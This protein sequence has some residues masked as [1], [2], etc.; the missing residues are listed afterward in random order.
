MSPAG[1]PADPY[2]ARDFE[3]GEQLARLTLGMDR[4]FRQ[5]TEA[6]VRQEEE[7]LVP[8]DLSGLEPLTL[9]SWA[10]AAL[11]LEELDEAIGGLGDTPHGK[12]SAGKS[13]R[14]SPRPRYL[15]EMIGSLRT[16]CA[17]F[18][19]QEVPFPVKVQRLLGVDPRRVPGSV[20]D[21]MKRELQRL[22]AD[23]G[24]RGE[25]ASQVRAFEEDGAL[26]EEEVVSTMRELLGEAAARTHEMVIPL[27]EFPSIDPV[28]V[29]DV[30]YTAYC[31]YRASKIYLNADVRF[32]RAALKHLA[33]HEAFP[34]HYTHLFIRE[35]LCR[36]GMMPL[37]GALVVTDTVSSPI[38][39]GIAE[40]G[41][42]LID[43]VEDDRDAA[44]ILLARLRSACGLN[45]AHMIHVQG[46]TEE[47]VAEYLR[48]E[49]FGQEGWIASRL[50]FLTSFLRGPFIYAYWRGDEA[51]GAA[52]RSAGRRLGSSLYREMHSAHTLAYLTNTIVD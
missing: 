47:E 10:E 8:V 12:A 21:D 17:W 29:R 37:D 33:A 49:A 28:L 46:R 13:Q 11:E 48:Q 50:R 43:W 27:P 4:L 41:I 20:L 15:G 32:T 22:L 18:A 25:L 7:E 23:M 6:G 2:R 35:H 9:R 42:H 34:G 16:M 19:G 24:Y 44:G 31:D 5:E 3:I 26:T 1:A 45:A 36:Q 39:E 40:Q 38:F 14:S 30:R 51:V 52:L